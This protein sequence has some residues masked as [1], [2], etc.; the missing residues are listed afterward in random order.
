M[1]A[2]IILTLVII[3]LAFLAIRHMKKN[4]HCSGCSSA[5]NGTCASCAMADKMVKDINEAGK[6]K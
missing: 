6:R 3:L 5:K 2:T 4:G 1:I